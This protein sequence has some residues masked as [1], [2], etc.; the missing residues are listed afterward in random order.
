MAASFFRATRHRQ[1][2]DHDRRKSSAR[3]IS[4]LLE[5]YLYGNH[6]LKMSAEGLGTGQRSDTVFRT[7]FIAAAALAMTGLGI[8]APPASASV[9]TYSGT[10][11]SGTTDFTNSVSTLQQFNPSM[12]TL[13]SVTITIGDSFTTTLTVTNNG[14]SASA[15]QASTVLAVGFVDAGNLFT[16]DKLIV[17]NNFATNYATLA[18]TSGQSYSLGIGGSTTLAQNNGSAT[19]VSTSA[20]TLASILN[21]F[22]GT[23]SVSIDVS[24]LTLTS[25]TN[26]GGNTVAAQ[27][28]SASVTDSVTYNYTSSSVPEPMSVALLGSG[29]IALGFLRRRFI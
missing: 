10:T 6:E 2:R 16:T 3:A 8:A 21:E 26:G 15:G 4:G 9:I 1:V 19:P 27:V 13:Q 12:G 25:L 5:C 24:T 11:V 7:S 23:G 17:T 20:L 18:Q 22:T 14:G 29:L 28:T